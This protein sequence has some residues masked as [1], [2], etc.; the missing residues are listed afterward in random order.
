MLYRVREW[1]LYRAIRGDAQ[2]NQKSLHRKRK[3]YR[4][5]KRKL[6]LVRKRKLCRIKR[7]ESC[8]DTLRNRKLFRVRER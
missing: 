5:R 7:R 2:S 8:T 4:V 3:F 1:K 6:Y